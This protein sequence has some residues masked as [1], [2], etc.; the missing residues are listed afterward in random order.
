MLGYGVG[1]AGTG[2]FSAVPNIIL[3]FFLTNIL[4][5][6]P[7][8]SAQIVLLPKLWVVFADPMTGY[9]SDRT[10]GRW[11][12]RRP[13]LFLGAFLGPLLFVLLFS[14]PGVLTGGWLSLYE[15]A[16]YFLFVTCFSIY[17]IPY[18]A[19]PSEIATSPY[20]L[21]RIMSIRMAFVLVG[22]LLAGTSPILVDMLGG[23]KKGYAGMAIVIGCLCSA[24]MIFP[25]FVLGK[26]PV[27]TI[28]SAKGGIWDQAKAFGRNPPFM[29]LA[30]TYVL[31]IVGF[32]VMTASMPYF[33]QNMWHSP[34]S[35]A[36]ELFLIMM[37]PG[38][39]SIPLW[40]FAARHLG[41]ANGLVLASAIFICASAGQFFVAASIPGLGSLSLVAC[42]GIA[43]GGQQVLAFALASQMIQ[44]FVKRS[45]QAAEGAFTGVW[46][47]GEKIGAA[48][49]TAMVGWLFGLAG[50]ITSTVGGATQTPETAQVIRLSFTLI[51]AFLFILSYLP[52]VAAI[53]AFRALNSVAGS[54]FDAQASSAGNSI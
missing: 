7:S 12:R 8:T 26:A 25:C 11:G 20:D 40:V 48:L 33:V 28:N 18:V 22:V 1:S 44:S 13:F 16:V 19:V 34:V 29:F 17:I 31:Q 15:G 4:G 49:G 53:R 51:P 27:Q 50:F 9:L 23:G 3:L 24:V 52:M 21:T 6:G 54:V 14:P 37:I 35:L 42:L 36:G 45:G 32:G 38:L 47:A 43:F 39:C 5:I 30:V 10:Q 2:V 46:M 41:N